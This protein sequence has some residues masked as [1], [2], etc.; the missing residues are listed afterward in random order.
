MHIITLSIMAVIKRKWRCCG[1]GLYCYVKGSG[2]YPVGDR[3]SL[4]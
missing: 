4:R 1:G 2:F 3:Q